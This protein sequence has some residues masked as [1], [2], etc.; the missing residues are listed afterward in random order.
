M[1]INDTVNEDY[2]PQYFVSTTDASPVTL[3]C[4]NIPEALPQEAEKLQQI[5]VD[6]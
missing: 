6:S 1:L 3:G 2:V 5:G 4:Q